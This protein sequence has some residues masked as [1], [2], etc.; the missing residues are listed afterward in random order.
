MSDERESKQNSQNECGW[1][2]NQ[3]RANTE[4]YLDC[5][6]GEEYIESFGT[7]DLE[8][9]FCDG[10]ES[11]LRNMRTDSQ[12]AYATRLEHDIKRLEDALAQQG[13]DY[14]A[15]AQDMR[16]RIVELEAE[17][18]ERTQRETNLRSDWLEARERI[19]ELETEAERLRRDIGLLVDPLWFKYGPDT[20]VCGWCDNG[21]S[22]EK[23][24]DDGHDENCIVSHYYHKHES[25]FTRYEER[26]FATIEKLEAENKRLKA[27]VLEAIR[28]P[29]DVSRMVEDLKMAVE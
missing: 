25:P 2:N 7:A 10:W 9:S 27:A 19:T 11:A 5:F 24:N 29:T 20:G 17:I 12:I 14:G 26:L 8:S 16:N 13:V 1:L 6:D 3:A 15:A 28:A 21:D 18:T 22:G 23:T 4:K